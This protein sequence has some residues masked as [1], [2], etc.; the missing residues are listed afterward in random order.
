M[1]EMSSADR[2]GVRTMYIIELTEAEEG[3]LELVD[4]AWC[5]SFSLF[6]F[7]SVAEQEE[8]ETETATEFAMSDA[9]SEFSEYSTMSRKS[10]FFAGSDRLTLLGRCYLTITA[11]KLG[12][13]VG[14]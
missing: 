3:G 9:R 5:E 7:L 1:T 6:S 11:R 10:S 12:R 4:P 13:P 14:L 8:M 2:P